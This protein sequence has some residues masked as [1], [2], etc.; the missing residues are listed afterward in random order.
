MQST[1]V[2]AEG[3]E[4]E[5]FEA[6]NESDVESCCSDCSSL[7]SPEWEPIEVDED[8]APLETEASGT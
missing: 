5:V 6:E 8:D 2:E 4:A 3:L 1:D 7:V